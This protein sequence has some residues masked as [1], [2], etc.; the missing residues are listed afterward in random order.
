MFVALTVCGAQPASKSTVNS[1]CAK[2][3]DDSI[4][5]NAAI[6]VTNFNPLITSAVFGF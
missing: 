3:F 1:T 5:Q 4:E 6:P 2:A